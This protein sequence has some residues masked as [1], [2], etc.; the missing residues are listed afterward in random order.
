MKEGERAQMADR[1]V[2]PLYSSSRGWLTEHWYWSHAI[3]KKYTMKG[4]KH[5]RAITLD[6][7]NQ[8]TS[9]RTAWREEG[10]ESETG[11]VERPSPQSGG[12]LVEYSVGLFL[13][14]VDFKSIGAGFDPR[15]CPRDTRCHN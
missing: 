5:S 1:V 12:V 7:E 6:K 9:L 14:A 15:R 2:S 10:R 13:G 4:A 8:S 3:T 11:W